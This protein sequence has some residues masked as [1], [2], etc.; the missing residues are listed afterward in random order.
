[1]AK[2]PQPKGKAPEAEEPQDAAA[3]EEAPKKKRFSGKK[4]VLFVI[5]PLLLLGGGGGAAAYFM[6]LFG[7][8]KADQAAEAQ[9]AAE[10]GPSTYYE[11]PEMLVNLV[12]TGKK[13]SYLK[14]KVSLELKDEEAS[15]QIDAVLPR[16][17]DSFQIYL[18][19]LRVDDLQ[20]SAGILRL[21]QELLTRVADAAKPTEVHDVLF[22]E[23]LVQ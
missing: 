11:M 5:L 20:G 21:R 9:A 14:L 16:I 4:L 3:A 13:P 17:V 2:A 15:K 10:A 19:A 22:K 23:M 6:G 7:G 1:M 12:T 8:A 18:R